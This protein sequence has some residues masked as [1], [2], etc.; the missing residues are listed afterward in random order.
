ML[1]KYQIVYCEID[2]RA[3]QGLGKY[4]QLACARKEGRV[5]FSSQRI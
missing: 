5:Y 3:E 1:G 4:N 2:T